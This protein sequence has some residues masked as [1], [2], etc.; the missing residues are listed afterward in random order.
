MKMG[1]FSSRLPA[2][3]AA[4]LAMGAL[5][6]CDRDPALPFEIEGTAEIDGFLFLDAARTG[7]YAPFDGDLPLAGVPFEVRDRGTT[8]VWAQGSGVTGTD[9]RFSVTGL[10]VGTHD[11]W[12]DTEGLPEGALLCQNPFPLSLYLSETTAAVIG[13]EPVCLISIQEA[14]DSGIDAFVNISGIVTSFP[15]QLRS[16]YTYIQDGSAGVRI[17][18]SALEGQGI[19]IGDRVTLT[20]TLGIFNDDLQITN[21]TVESVEPGVGAPTPRLASTGALA[22]AGP[23]PADPLQGRLVVVRSARLETLFTG[24]GNRNARIN[25]GSGSIEMRIEAAIS[26]AGNAINERF[27]LDACYDV[28]GVVGNF[29]GTTQVFPRSFDDINEVACTGDA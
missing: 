14:K 9:G 17:F 7:V 22:E 6:A 4:C 20:G 21:P 26:A 25:D 13:A 2:W 19:E 29:R 16:A 15:G 11:L 12:F 18:S 28:V 8:R 1:D 10:P 3:T 27:T 5:V 23:T 24:G